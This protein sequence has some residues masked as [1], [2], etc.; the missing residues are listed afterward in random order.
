MQIVEHSSDQYKPRTVH[1]AESSD[2]N[3]AFALDFNTAGERLTKKSAN[4]K[5][6]AISL[7][8]ESIEAARILYK[9]SKYF[10]VE[11]LNIAGNGIY[12]LA[13]CGWTQEFLNQWIFDVI[14]LVHKH[15]PFSKIISGGQT[16]VDLAGGVAAEVLSIPCVMTFPKGLIQRDI[17]G[18]TITQSKE[19]LMDKVNY[20]VDLIKKD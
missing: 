18:K 15:R 8:M 12:S 9:A 7:N 3:V 1:N 4:G 20:Y 11:T 2:L 10:N 19:E 13:D 16:G 17:N 6:V 5:Y 14:S